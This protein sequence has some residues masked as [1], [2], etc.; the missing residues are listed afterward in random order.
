MMTMKNILKQAAL[1]LGVILFFVVLF[2]VFVP[3]VLDGKVLNQSDISQWQGMSHEIHEWN[4]EH[5]D[6][7]TLWT[8]SMFGGMPTVGMY[9][10]F[11]GDYTKWIYQ[12]LMGLKRPVSFLFVTLLGAFLLMLAFGIH[13][14]LS[15]AGAVAVAFCSYNMQIIQV[16]HNAKMQ[17]IAFAPWVLAAIVYAYRTALG[18]LAAT[19]ARASIAAA[20][21]Y[22][23]PDASPIPA[24]K[25][26]LPRLGIASVLFALALSMQI[27]ANHVQISYYLAILIFIYVLV[28]VVDILRRKAPVRGAALRNFAV[29]SVLLLVMGGVGIATNANKLIPTYNYTQYTMRGGSELTSDS[30]THNSKGLDLDYATQWSYGI[31]EMPNL[32]IPNFRGGISEGL[33]KSSETYKLLRSA[34]HPEYAAYFQEYWGPQPFTAGP[35]YLGAICCFLFMLGLFLFKGKEK[36]WLLAATILASFLAWGNHFM[37]FT[38]FFFEYVPMY[39]KFRSVSMALTVLQL[40]V[41]VL[42]FL[43]L[44][45]ILK[46]EYTKKEFSTK[47]WI[48]FGLTGGFCLLCWLFPSVA[49]S[50]LTEAEQGQPETLLQALQADRSALLVADARRSFFFIALTFALLLWVEYRRDGRDAKPVSTSAAS[51]SAT[52]QNSPGFSL[53]GYGTP[54]VVAL[55]VI[56]VLVLVDL[57]SAGKR[58]LS[59]DDFMT[60]KAYKGQFTEREADKWIHQD[61]DPSYRVLDLSV[62][63][64]N[65]AFQCY[66]HKCVG[67]YSPVKLQRYQDLI[68]RYIFKE[69]SRAE[70][71]LSKVATLSEFE[72]QMPDMP[73]VS[74]MNGRYIIVQKDLRAAVNEGAFGNAW[75]VRSVREAATPDEEIALLGQVDLHRQAVVGKDYLP[76][77]TPAFVSEVGGDEAAGLGSGPEPSDSDEGIVLT[78]YAPNEL[79]YTFRTDAPAL[80]VFSEVFHPIGW[81]ARIL[82]HP[83]S[84]K[85]A[86]VASPSSSTT[87]A[88]AVTS[89]ASA[90]PVLPVSEELPLVRANW[91]LRAAQLPAGEGEIVMRYEP[92]DYVLGANISRASSILLYLL[93]LLSLGFAN[94]PKM[95][96]K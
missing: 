73:I 48:A 60:K 88:S 46:G 63:T 86:D 35:M 41:P 7:K 16:G 27:K 39:S 59:A 68:D 23:G 1:M 36:W 78:R 76:Q 21:K 25:S 50:F 55:S 8:G 85:A 81:K 96:A 26:I 29:A 17:A 82:Y 77:V 58:Y 93:L 9:D 4:K 67:G 43:V 54:A 40:T 56:S 49:G 66:H 71:V 69:I 20:Q 91:L 47:A 70:K 38:R 11:E 83:A 6:D 34:G 5:P 79:H 10:D 30:D 37:A 72:E 14:L 13:P 90:E 64:F 84:P 3:E 42:A 92:E 52:T 75:L 74:M 18:E 51:G 65:D 15:V 44:D 61:T 53:K 33:P 45:K 19:P 28:L 24:L 57:F 62:N 22:A 87:A 12:V 94:L 31:E 89:D 2:Y 32:M 95:F 80:A